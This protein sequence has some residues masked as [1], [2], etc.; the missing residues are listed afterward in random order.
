MTAVVFL[1]VDG[2]LVPL[3]SLTGDPEWG[4]WAPESV[5]GMGVLGVSAPQLHAVGTLPAQLVWATDWVDDAND[6]LGSRIG[7][8]S[9]HVCQ[10]REGAG[11]DWWKLGAITSWLADNEDVR[12]VVWIDDKIGEDGPDGRSWGAQLSALLERTGVELLIVEP[13]A[14]V[15]LTVARWT[16][17]SAWLAGARP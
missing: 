15:G 6:V 8:G 2:A 11:C 4:D 7:R 14:D 3:R 17:I 5:P 16:A 9:L 13:D 10:R 1:D 12:R